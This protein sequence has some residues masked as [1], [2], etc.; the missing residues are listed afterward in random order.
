MNNLGC[1][2]LKKDQYENSFEFLRKAIEIQMANI[3]RER[4]KNDSSDKD[5]MS[6]QFIL[7]CR[8]YNR[9]LSCQKYIMKL[10]EEYIPYH[11]L[12]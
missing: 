11:S 1:I 8:H 9:A 4:I 10:I 7:A 6:S 3:E 2:Y 5:Q 12:T